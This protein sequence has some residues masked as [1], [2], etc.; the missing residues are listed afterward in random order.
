MNYF[1]LSNKHGLVTIILCSVHV[2]VVSKL[3]QGMQFSFIRNCQL[4]YGF[5][6]LY[7]RRTLIITLKEEIEKKKIKKPK[8]SRKKNKHG[9][10]IINPRCMGKKIKN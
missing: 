5:L 8:G 7:T 9:L 1:D 6:D 3:N 4:D 2:I 10:V